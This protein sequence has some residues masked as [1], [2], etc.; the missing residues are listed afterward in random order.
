MQ[1]PAK[2]YTENDDEHQRE[3]YG[4]GVLHRAVRFVVDVSEG[5]GDAGWRLESVEKDVGV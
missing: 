1:A 3:D 2:D 4:V 5:C